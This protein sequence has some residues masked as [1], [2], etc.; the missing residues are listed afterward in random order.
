MQATAERR[1]PFSCPPKV[2]KPRRRLGE[3][4]QREGRA[5]KRHPAQSSPPRSVLPPFYLQIG[6]TSPTRGACPFA[7]SG[8]DPR[9][10]CDQRS[11]TST[12][13]LPYPVHG[14]KGAGFRGETLFRTPLGRTQQ[15]TTSDRPSAPVQPAGKTRPQSLDTPIPGRAP[16]RPGPPGRAGGLRAPCGVFPG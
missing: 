3:G 13:L 14:C 2:D 11:N 12:W 9:E 5:G 15:F 10:C 7:R 1:S 16:P 8:H 4:G 6:A